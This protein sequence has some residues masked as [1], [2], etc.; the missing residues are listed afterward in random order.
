MNKSF[1][2]VMMMAALVVG[3]CAAK[4]KMSPGKSAAEVI[5]RAEPKKGYRP[6]QSG[7]AAYGAVGGQLSAGPAASEGNFTQIDYW[8]MHGIVVWV[9]PVLGTLPS[10]PQQTLTISAPKSRP[11]DPA[12]VRVANLGDKIVVQNRARTTETFYVRFEDGAVADI[13]TL[14]GGAVAAYQLR[15]PGSQ[16]VVSESN[17]RVIE[18]IFVAP[19]PLHR[20]THCNSTVTFNDLAPGEYRLKSWHYRLPGTSAMLNLAPGKVGKATVVIGVNALPKVQ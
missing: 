5:V 15:R 17:D 18:R 16:V 3:G 19:S 14:G 13:G 7:S 11:P 6:P 10:P 8:D 1:L 4:G 9:E 2:I 20:V 12:E